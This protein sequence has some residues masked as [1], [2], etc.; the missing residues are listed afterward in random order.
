MT[1]E[2]RHLYLQIDKI[3]ENLEMANNLY[4]I[5]NSN[6]KHYDF[7]VLELIKELKDIINQEKAEFI[8]AISL[9]KQSLESQNSKNMKLVQDLC[10]QTETQM[11]E[12]A[13]S[14]PILSYF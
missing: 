6:I 2:S 12:K 10:L 4:S 13:M 14:N 3:K 9:T 7:E 11:R 1:I 8:R 5:L